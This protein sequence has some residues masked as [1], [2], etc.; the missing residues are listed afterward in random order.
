MPGAASNENAGLQVEVALKL[1]EI[2]GTSVGRIRFF[3]R[4]TMLN[5]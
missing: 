4:A 2:T 1:V 3:Y 5:S